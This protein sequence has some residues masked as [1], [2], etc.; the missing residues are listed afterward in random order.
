MKTL[1]ALLAV[2]LMFSLAAFAQAPAAPEASNVYA[3]GISLNANASPAVAGTGLYAHKLGN[4]GTYAFTVVDALPNTLKPF[5]VT[6]NFG[7]GIAQKV[8]SIGPVPIY[9]PSS[10][11]VSYTGQNVGWAWST[12][13]MGSIKLK[14]KSNWRILP[15]VRIVKSS[16]SNGTG[17]QPII[18]V[19]F[20]WA[21]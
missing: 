2:M 21:E 7:G 13:A 16:V 10:A 12:G 15:N 5:T 1:F 4:A 14:A 17:Y 18:G 20:G 8:F 9:I 3:A 11:G 19:L 6:T